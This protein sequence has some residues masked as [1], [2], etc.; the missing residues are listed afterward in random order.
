MNYKLE[1]HRDV[2]KFFKKHKEKKLLLSFKN[3]T[4]EIKKN[5]R[6]CENCDVK[7]MQGMENDYRLRI[8][9]YRFLYQVIDEKI[10]VFFYSANSRGAIYKNR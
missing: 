1:Y 4:D 2:V 8:G 3:A 6:Q 7:K 10:L 5:P 9:K